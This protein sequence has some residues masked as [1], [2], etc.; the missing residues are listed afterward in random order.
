MLLLE[1]ARGILR[2]IACQQNH[3]TEVTTAPFKDNSRKII[4]NA[5]VQVEVKSPENASLQLDSIIRHYEAYISSSNNNKYTIKVKSAYF[6]RFLKK[7]GTL[8]NIKQQSIQSE[9]VTEEFVDYE[10]R[11]ENAERTRKKYLEILDTST[12]V[13]DALEVQKELDRINRNIDLLKG[14]LKKL[15]HLTNYAT[16]TVSLN[17]KTKPGI[18]G[19]V[20]IGLIHSIKWLFVRN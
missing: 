11:L 17:E 5:N 3:Q 4:F 14:K 6:N 12:S 7:I 19:Y 8:G 13:S 16:I 15:S 1:S 18:I 2:I 10:I 9:D 20:A